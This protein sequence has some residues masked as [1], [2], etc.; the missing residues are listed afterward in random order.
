MKN[1][2][3]ALKDVNNKCLEKQQ[4]E[5]SNKLDMIIQEL[6]EMNEPLEVKKFGI[7]KCVCGQPLNLSILHCKAKFCPNCS[8]GLKWVD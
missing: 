7:V 6:E 8:Q 1:Q 4:Y 5:I 3:Q 2:I